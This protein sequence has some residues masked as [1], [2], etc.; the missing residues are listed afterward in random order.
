[1][2]ILSA[3]KSGKLV[4]SAQYN[5][6]LSGFLDDHLNEAAAN[7][8]KKLV[9]FGNGM[10]DLDVYLMAN[11]QSGVE[12]ARWSQSVHR[13]GYQGTQFSG[14]FQPFM[15][16]GEGVDADMAADI[17]VH[18]NKDVLTNAIITKGLDR[19]L[20]LYGDASVRTLTLG[21]YRKVGAFDLPDHVLISGETFVRDANTY[22]CRDASGNLVFKDTFQAAPVTLSEMAF[23][24]AAKKISLAP[25]YA[26]AVIER[27]LSDNTGSLDAGHDYLTR[28][29]YYVWSTT[30][31]SPQ[32]FDVIVRWQVP[33]GFRTL[34]DIRL[35]HKVSNITTGSRIDVYLV[36]ADG[37]SVT[38]SGGSN[39]R[40]ASWTQ[41]VITHTGGVFSAGDWVTLKIRMTA[42]QNEFAYIGELEINI[43]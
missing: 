15:L 4:R 13:W 19:D 12:Y 14:V 22:Y 11:Q 41:A 16:S 24:A 20:S 26:G 8:H 23:G 43:T 34:A 25:E 37:T 27:D 32:D 31:A 30:S 29:N 17:L 2:S 6:L 40:Q 5:N 21:R 1:M 18:T 28:H 38:I 33:A 3:V 10:D 35:Y 7:Y 39:L 9:H 36:Q 42:A